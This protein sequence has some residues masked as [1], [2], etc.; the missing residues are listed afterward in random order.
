MFRGYGIFYGHGYGGDK[1]KMWPFNNEKIIFSH[2]SD[3]VRKFY[4]IYPASKIPMKWRTKLNRGVKEKHKENIHTTNSSL[5]DGI[6]SL[7]DHSYVVRC[8]ID[9]KIDTKGDGREFFWEVPSEHSI[10]VLGENP[11]GY[12]PASTY[13]DYVDLPANT[14]KTVIK[15]NTGWRVSVPKNY[16]L[17]MTPSTYN[18]ENRFTSTIGIIDCT[19]ANYLNIPLLWHILE[20]STVI[21]AGTPLALLTLVP[22]NKLPFHIKEATPKDFILEKRLSDTQ[23]MS[24]TKPASYYMRAFDKIE[25]K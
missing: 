15:I 16:K 20:G 19:F 6:R 5:C 2:K 8:P 14:L 7:L 22:E 17:I 21:E 9:I 3:L 1:I 10:D 18:E 12:F 25:N 24:F 13:G 23:A 11:I 4:P